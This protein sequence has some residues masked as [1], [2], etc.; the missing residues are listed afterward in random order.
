MGLSV[1]NITKRSTTN[2]KQSINGQ[3]GIPPTVRLDR[4][5]LDALTAKPT[6]LPD[7][8]YCQLHIAH[9]IL[10]IITTLGS[11]DSS[12]TGLIPKADYVVPIIESELRV[13][14]THL[15]PYWTRVDYIS[16]CT[17]KLILYIIAISAA[18][19][20]S[21]DIDPT[22][23]EKRSQWIVQGYMCSIGMIQ[24]ASTIQE[25]LI[26]LPTR[27]YKTLAAAV[28]FLILLK[29][30]KY[31]YLADDSAL[32]IAIRQ[33]WELTRKFELVQSDFITRTNYLLERLSIY[34]E[35]LTPEEKTGELLTGKARMGFNVAR[36]TT[37]L[38]HQVVLKRNQEN[39]M[40][41]DNGTKPANDYTMEMA[42]LDFFLDFDWNESLL[43]LP[44][45]TSST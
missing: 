13:A 15:S 24:A 10:K 30:S 35:T 37:M 20:N 25:P 17:C 4:G 2:H 27:I 26:K 6:W 45:P 7:T 44:G 33:G 36:S 22:G 39:E 41:V 38:V 14:E 11:Y 12:T 32:T 29:C 31:Y 43:S 8:L 40:V 1:L 28:S 21:D 16:F 3:L 9:H 5:L 23:S 19:N 42:D 34:S 18:D